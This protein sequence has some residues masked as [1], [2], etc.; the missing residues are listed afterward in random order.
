MA[1]NVTDPN[2]ESKVLESFSRQ[3]FMKTLG[4]KMT[5]VAPGFCEI[6]LPFHESLTQQNQYLHAGSIAA[7]ADSASGYAAFTL[8]PVNT[9]V[10]TTEYKINLISPGRK[11]SG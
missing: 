11:I 5:R 1:L 4:A 7:I 8:A 6:S 10:L 2:F 3:K 9:F